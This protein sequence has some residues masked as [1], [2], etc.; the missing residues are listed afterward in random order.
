[1]L[2]GHTWSDSNGILLCIDEP[3]ADL[4]QRRSGQLE[5]LSYLTITHPADRAKSAALVTSLRPGRGPTAMRKRYLTGEGAEIWVVLE[6]ARLGGG[7][8][9]EHLLGSFIVARNDQNP[10][11]LWR[12]AKRLL[13]LNVLRGEM[14]GAELFSDHSWSI[15]LNLYLAEAEGRLIDSNELTRSLTTSLEVCQRWITALVSRGL[16]D[17]Y[18]A[19]PNVCQLTQLGL[20]AVEAVLLGTH[21]A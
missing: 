8:S 5:G 6:A 7:T 16:V 18:V 10:R 20:E 15:L 3:V 2:V 1:M 12:E 21:A 4:L 11:R 14:L 19:N 9:S 13:D 17:R